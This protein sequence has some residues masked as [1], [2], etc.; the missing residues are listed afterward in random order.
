MKGAPIPPDEVARLAALDEYKILDTEAEA[1][2][3][4]VTALVG[5]LLG[6]PI[7][8]I[9]IVD[10]NRQWFKSRYGLAAPE[11]TRNISFCGH[12]VGGDTDLTVVDAFQDG[13]F[14]DNPLVTGDPH[15]R[16]YAG[17][18]LRTPEGFVLGT[19]CAIDHKPRTLSGAQEKILAALARQVVSLLELRR[20][21]IV[22]E[23]QAKAIHN[24]ARF[25]EL[26]V[27]L[28]ATADTSLHLIDLNPSWTTVLGWSLE[29]LR[30]RPLIEF[31][32]PDDREATAIEA[33]R[34]VRESGATV[35]FENR[36][37]HK[38]GQW[39][40]LSWTARFED[41]LFF[42]TAND[43]RPQH[44][45]EAMIRARDVELSEN[46]ARLRALFGGMGEG[47]VLQVPSGEIT[48]C[49][50]AAETILG[51]THAQLLGRSSIDPRWRAV[52]EDGSLFPGETHPAIV[53][54][55]TGEPQIN[56]VMGVH[57]PGGE[58]TWISINAL[59]LRRQDEERPHGAVTTFRDITAQ[60]AAEVRAAR[61]VRQE[62]LVTTGT[63]AAGV[64]HEINNPLT[65]IISN[66]EF[67]L[68]ELGEIAGGS[69]SG[70]LKGLIEV[71]TEA[72][73]GAE[74]IRKIVRGLRSL[75]QDEGPPVPI[76][77]RPTVEAAVN[78]AM[79]ELRQRATVI[80]EFPEL[81]R[82]LANESGLT[83]VLV[84]LLVNAA[85]AFP[86]HDPGRNRVVVGASHTGDVVSITVAD[87]GPGIAPDDL[88]RIFD[89]FWTTKPVGVGTGLG[90]SI[91]HS[92]VTA[93]GGD[94]RCETSLG[95][96]ATFIVRLPVAAIADLDEGPPGSKSQA[97]R[98]HILI[99][100]DEAALIRSFDRLLRADHD[101]VGETDPREALA[102]LK[103]GEVFDLI[104]CDIM[105]P[106]LT[107]PD[108]YRAAQEIAPKLCERFVFITGGVLS[109]STERFL[110]E[111]PNERFEKPLSAQTLRT[112]ARRFLERRPKNAK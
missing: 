93:L 60:K 78:M 30:S 35:N 46:E 33:Q 90:L 108:L 27:D 8:L 111:V 65:Y 106:Y 42:S 1:A 86:S 107:G 52:H 23:T 110:S 31:V 76:D 39:I 53:C 24:L 85:Q 109:E 32:H 25:F 55:R 79:H 69:P 6:V 22:V 40:P 105:M 104:I 67:S 50:A 71:V 11:T 45:K 94:L 92:I 54:L 57:K 29:E 66:L 102:R 74:R 34:L 82:V 89:P 41:G 51:L 83:Q 21:S 77:I 103:A 58:L 10:E 26:S 49:N 19:L 84:N 59:P 73:A 16:F 43:L 17:V 37:Q 68:E 15:V 4:A 96:G 20:K 61:L 28:F 87:N 63:L 12:V 99:V 5:D 3:D 48:T 72:R 18:P 64:G 7:A 100:D 56:V 81:P 44:T 75:A 112:T 97:L 47:V 9:S 91:S 13:R 36:Y 98:A 62:R 70:R 14:S 2:F 38:D 80:A 88:S 95:A 101:V